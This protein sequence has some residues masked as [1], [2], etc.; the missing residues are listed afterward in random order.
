MEI[1]NLCRDFGSRIRRFLN[2]AS[3]LVDE[4][5]QSIQR[6]VQTLK[7][8]EEDLL[9]SSDNECHMLRVFGDTMVHCG[10][11]LDTIDVVDKNASNQLSYDFRVS[12][13]E[14]VLTIAND[15]GM[16]LNEVKDCIDSDG[17]DALSVL[18]IVGSTLDLVVYLHRASIDNAIATTSTFDESSPSTKSSGFPLTIELVLQHK[19]KHY[20][21][22]TL[23]LSSRI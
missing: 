11:V 9:F 8:F 7:L 6:L 20:K 12:Y 2:D 4:A 22:V 23:H 13:C 14:Q 5:R 10:D 15:M 18:C 1:I 16:I 19:Q 21:G 3:S 17:F